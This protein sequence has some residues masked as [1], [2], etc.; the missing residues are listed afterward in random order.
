MGYKPLGV[1]QTEEDK[2]YRRY[3]TGKG[4]EMTFSKRQAVAKIDRMKSSTNNI[5]RLLK[6][7]ELPTVK[8]LEEADIWDDETIAEL[9]EHL[10]ACQKIITNT[11]KEV[12]GLIKPYETTRRQTPWEK[13]KRV[14]CPECKHEFGMVGNQSNDKD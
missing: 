14:I 4:V 3:W 5:L 6:R 1:Q 2:L 8:E 7:I 9:E 10:T 11:E 12:A 13:N